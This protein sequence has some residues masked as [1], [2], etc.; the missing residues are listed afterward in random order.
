MVTQVTQQSTQ[1]SWPSAQ[2]PAVE[3]EATKTAPRGPAARP[4]AQEV[5]WPCET[6]QRPH[7]G[8]ARD[9]EQVR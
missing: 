3:R 5:H 1:L 9:G 2:L 8:E 7:R 4:C 6:G